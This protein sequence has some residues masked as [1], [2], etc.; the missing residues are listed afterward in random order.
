MEIYTSYF[1]KIHK[2]PSD[3]IPISICGKAPDWYKGLQYKKIAPK[4]AFFME[5]KENHD[6]DFYTKCYNEQVLS[7]LNPH[8]V[9]MD[10]KHLCG[11]SIYD[12]VKICLFCYEEPNKFCHR[13]LFTDW[14]K[15]NG[16]ECE[17]LILD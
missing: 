16:Y 4:K 14:L 12:D 9:I 5:W 13:H 17:E 10:L 15:S 8:T 2:L 3:I 6:N 11:I 7:S 1:G